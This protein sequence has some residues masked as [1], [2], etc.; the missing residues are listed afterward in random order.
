[1]GAKIYICKMCGRAMRCE[2]EPTYCYFDRMDNSQAMGLENVTDE[3]ATLMEIT[4][5]FINS[6]DEIFEF[7]GDVRYDP[8]AGTPIKGEG[9]T[10]TEFQDRV[11]ERCLAVA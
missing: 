11:L 1:M 2:V 8:M 9:F 4:P 3:N 6:P 10:L 7:P 5:Q